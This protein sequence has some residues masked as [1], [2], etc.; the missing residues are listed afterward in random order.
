MSQQAIG[1]AAGPDA[2][3]EPAG[4]LPA[5]PE[6]DVSLSP[7]LTALK[8]E[9]ER[10]VNEWL[11]T[12]QSLVSSS[13]YDAVAFT[14]TGLGDAHSHDAQIAY[15]GT[16]FGPDAGT[17]FR[18]DMDAYF[19]DPVSELAVDKERF[20]VLANPVLPKSTGTIVLA[21][22]DPEAPPEIR[23]NYYSDPYDL[24]VMVAVMRRA[25]EIVDGWPGEPKPGSRARGR[26]PEWRSARAR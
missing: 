16:N 23:F 1:I 8:A 6:D 4:P 20:V 22:P 5:N 25:L 9:S 7:E 26:S 2:L 13:I 24:K 18:I 11:E 15:F 3:R 12:G 19:D 14:S 10:L 21:G 17:L